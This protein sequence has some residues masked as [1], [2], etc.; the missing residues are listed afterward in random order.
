M[1][2]PNDSGKE[3]L[4]HIS[5]LKK[6]NRRPQ[7]GDSILYEIIVEADGKIRAA[8]ASI[9]G[10]VTKPV[11][12]KQKQKKQNSLK[13]L[14]GIIISAAIALLAIEFNAR[15]SPSPIQSIAKP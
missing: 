11:A 6:T 4:L 14:G 7:V 3:V 12:I 13:T 1:I 15:S 9:Q 2:K 10:I 8:N 5:G